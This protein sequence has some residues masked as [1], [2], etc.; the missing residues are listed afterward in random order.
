MTNDYMLEDMYPAQDREPTWFEIQEGQLPPIAWETF[1]ARLRHANRA[2]HLGEWIFV[3]VTFAMW[4]WY[5]FWLY[6]AIRNFDI[7]PVP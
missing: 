7:V 3:A 1:P 4:G 2:E 5:M 6:T